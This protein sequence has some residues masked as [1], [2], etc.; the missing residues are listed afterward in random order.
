MVPIKGVFEI[1]GLNLKLMKYLFSHTLRNVWDEWGRTRKK[2]KHHLVF[3]CSYGFLLIPWF[4][5]LRS[6]LTVEMFVPYVMLLILGPFV[7][8]TICWL[9]YFTINVIWCL[10]FPKTG[11]QWRLSEKES[12]DGYIFLTE[13][14][15]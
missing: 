13:K 4:L 9:I 5:L 2:E 15:G 8:S 6:R 1:K 3:W 11:V 12:R 7:F 10:I 14:K